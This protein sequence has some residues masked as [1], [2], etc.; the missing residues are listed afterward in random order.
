MTRFLTFTTLSIIALAVN[1]QYP[2]GMSEADMQQMMQGAQA[3]ASCMENVDQAAMEQLSAEGE[4]VDAEVKALCAAGK[5]DEAQTKAMAFGMKVAN[6]PATKAIAECGK[7]MQGAVP[8]MQQIPY[9][10]AERE[11]ANRHVC[12]ELSR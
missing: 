11:L 10:D 7:H 9:A 2:G 12:D 3:M 4:Q 1:A 5:R 6:D 8:Q